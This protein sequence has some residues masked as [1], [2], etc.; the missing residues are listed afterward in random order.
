MEMQNSLFAVSSFED[1]DCRLFSTR[2]ERPILQPDD[3]DFEMQFS[4]R[5]DKLLIKSISQEGF[6]HFLLNY[7]D[8]Y[9]VLYLSDCSKIFD[10]SPLASLSNLEALAI[11]YNK[12][13]DRLWDFSSNTNLKVLSIM[14]SKKLIENPLHLQTSG[15][16]EEIRLWSS[17][18]EHPHTLRSMECFR[19]MKSLKRIDLNNIKLSDKNMDVLA[20]LPGLEE[21]H[22]DPGMLTTEEIARICAKYPHLHGYSLRAYD[23]THIRAGEVRVCGYRKPTLYLPKQQELLNK[24]ILQF[25]K[26]VAQFKTENHNYTGEK[27]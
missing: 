6:E 18:L 16:L 27:I 22:F 25:K 1:T 4:K 24:Y 14:D 11:D 17:G 13:S 20:T 8:T 23:D 3:I 26:L 21:F 15:S 2:R 19:G 7:G 12:K 10:L 5:N 9:K